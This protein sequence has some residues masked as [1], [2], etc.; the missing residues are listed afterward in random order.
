MG[1]S[2]GTRAGAGCPIPEGHHSQELTFSGGMLSLRRMTHD[3][4]KSIVKIGRPGARRRALPTK[5]PGLQEWPVRDGPLWYSSR[6]QGPSVRTGTSLPR[7][8]L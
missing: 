4:A 6:V 1:D 7:K 8:R 3:G 5:G 2:V